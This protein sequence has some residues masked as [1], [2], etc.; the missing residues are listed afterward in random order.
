MEELNTI[1]L[2]QGLLKTKSI[3]FKNKITI[4]ITTIFFSTIGFGA[5][6]WLG[7]SY[8]AQMSFVAENDK[9]SKLGG[10]SSIAAQFGID[11][12]M[13]G[14]SLFEGDN[15]VEFFKSRKMVDE[16]LLT[17]CNNNKLFIEWYIEIYDLRRKWQDNHELANLSY[18]SKKTDHFSRIH[19]S[20][21]NLVAEKIIRKRLDVSKPDKKIDIIYLKM[22]SKN[23]EFAVK[24]IEALA[25]NAINFYSDYKTRKS[26]TNVEIIQHQVDSVRNVL[27]G[28]IS[29]VASQN[30]LNVNPLKQQLRVN[31]QK[32]QFNIQVASA[33]YIELTK[34]LELAKLN[35]LKETPLIQIIDKPRLP[36]ENKTLGKLSF[37]IIFGILGFL[38]STFFVLIKSWF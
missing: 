13:S 23:Q 11:I 27:Y 36:L 2:K 26:R 33:V 9:A 4:I 32:G 20:I 22:Q 28:G 12:G 21:L 37:I 35:L 14:G 3:I 15:L 19:D 10:Y 6:L 30:D 31:S 1:E 7:Q 5:F 18:G 38:F 17:K 8:T 34:N 16:T 29:Q 24:F 25:N